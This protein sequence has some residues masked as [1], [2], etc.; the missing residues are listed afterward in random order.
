MKRQRRK[1]KAKAAF[2]PLDIQ[3]L[4]FTELHTPE[5][6]VTTV[7]AIESI[8]HDGR[9]VV[10]EQHEV[11]PPPPLSPRQ[12]WM[13]TEDSELSTEVVEEPT[14]DFDFDTFY[15]SAA[16]GIH[17]E[18]VIHNVPSVH[19]RAKRYLSSVSG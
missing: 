4:T 11:T 12:K 6:G 9:R 13:R 2:E 7:A 14:H 8:S 3:E 17:G 5:P 18:D 16:L 15:D 10:R 1:R 19:S